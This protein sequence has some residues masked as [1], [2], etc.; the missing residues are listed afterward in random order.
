M[1]DKV[2]GLTNTSRAVKIATDNGDIKEMASDT[3]VTRRYEGPVDEYNLTEEERQ[4]YGIRPDEIT[5][6][7]RHPEEWRRLGTG[8]ADDVSERL[9]A[10]PGARVIRDK[11][12]RHVTCGGDLCLIVYPR[13]HSEKVQSSIDT[14]ADGY[15]ALDPEMAAKFGMTAEQREAV[16]RDNGPY[17]GS[18]FGIS[19]SSLDE[20]IAK[21]AAPQRRASSPTL[22]MTYET[23]VDYQL[24]KI[25]SDAEQSGIRLSRD[26]ALQKLI[27][28]R[29]RHEERILSSY[30][31]NPDNN[32]YDDM[33]DEWAGST[34][35]TFGVG[36]GSDTS[37]ETL[38]A[39]K[40]IK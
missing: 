23:A 20:G 22:G 2:N 14:C 12:G 5:Y 19:R 34:G 28:N 24:S 30:S 13:E 16:L 18:E 1:S 38:R 15:I 39:R 21:A 40:K 4:E 36:F 37:A 25:M 31:F 29:E 26:E 33:M 27:D 32:D 8:V 3:N 10:W 35:S 17:P 11:Q 9:R 6:W 7:A